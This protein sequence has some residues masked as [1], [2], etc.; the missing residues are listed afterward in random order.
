MRRLCTGLMLSGIVLAGAQPGFAAAS[1][2]GSELF[3]LSGIEGTANGDEAG[4]AVDPTAGARRGRWSTLFGGAARYVFMQEFSHTLNEPAEVL[5]NRSSLRLKWN[6]FFGSRYYM[7]FDGKALAYYG[8]DLR[9]DQG[10]DVTPGS[11]I[12]EF[13]VQG[14]WGR[15][16]VSL[17][18]QLVIWGETETATVTDVFSPR[19]LTDFIFTSL[20]ESRIGQIMLKLQ[21]HDDYGQWTLLANPDVQTNEQ[22]Q[23]FTE[24]IDDFIIRDRADAIDGH[25]YGLRWKRPIGGADYS[26]M[27]ATLI[28]NDGVLHAAGSRN[29]M[30]LLDREY[31]R[32]EMLGGAANLNYGRIGVELEA[33]FN[34]GFPHQKS[35]LRGMVKRNRLLTAATL[36]YSPSG[37]RELV[38][39]AANTYVHGDTEALEVVDKSTWDFRFEWLEKYLH[40]TLSLSY[41]FQ[42]QL[43]TDHTLNQLSS[44]YA[45]TDDLFVRLDLFMIDGIGND[46]TFEQD[47][48]YLTL[49][50]NF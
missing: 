47:S 39:G 10:S 1:A 7:A 11:N 32:Y 45:F 3:D 36:K 27:A 12:K 9:A 8:D 34:R 14:N 48:L 23:I 42:Y 24:S 46:S 5:V 6:R 43:D 26:L 4:A 13:Y 38:F 49:E 15:N 31:H 16:S 40:D 33:A 20:D 25:E 41:T 30:P 21:R 35:D 17:G 19:N 44:R 37:V 2:T 50:Y 22:P 18:R 29:G 28:D